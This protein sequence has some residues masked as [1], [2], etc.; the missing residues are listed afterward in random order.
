[1]DNYFIEQENAQ[2]AE[3]GTAFFLHGV[4]R[5]S[6]ATH[7]HLHEAVEMIYV[8]AGNH[9]FYINEQHYLVKQGDLMLFRS[10][11]VH[12]IVSRETDWNRY[13]VLMI[14]PSVLYELASK[15]RAAEYLLRLVLEGG[16]CHWTREELENSPIREAFE[17]QINLFTSSDP[18]RDL[19]LKIGGIQIVLEILRDIF[20]NEEE[21]EGLRGSGENTARIY[22]TIYYINHHYGE[23]IDAQKCCTAL[24]VSYSYFSRSF[25]AITGKSFKEYL[26]FVRVNQAERMLLSTNKSIMDVAF[27]CGFNNVSYFIKV[28]KQLKG[29][30]PLS[31]RRSF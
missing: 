4:P 13:Y 23:E 12:K 6:V 20:Q 10:N 19:S 2:L 14:K 25:K 1:M 26:N 21:P 16:K 30:T 17:K 15:D 7:S 27:D 11:T 28:F 31:Y 29:S 9:D 24:N 5:F 3:N 8:T 22:K 18:C